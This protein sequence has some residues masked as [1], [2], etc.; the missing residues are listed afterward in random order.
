MAAWL[1]AT[2]PCGNTVAAET[3]KLALDTPFLEVQDN[4]PNNDAK[5]G[6]FCA[7][8]V[9]MDGSV[10]VFKNRREQGIITVKRSEDG[11]KTWG[12]E[13]EVGKKVKIDGDMTDDGRYR[14]AH[15]GWSELG[16][17]IVDENTGD[18]MV[19]PT[20][21]KT[22]QILYRSKDHG[23]TWKTEKTVIQPDVNGWLC[24][25]MNCETGITLRYGKKKGRLLMPTRVFVGYLNK[26]QNRKYYDKH[27]SNA[28]YSD[29]GGKTWI[30]SAPF[31]LGGT[32]EA[33][34]AELSDGRIYYNSRTHN[35]PG[36]RRIAWSY[37][38]GETW[39]DEHE[40]DEL[41]DGPP[42]V[43]GCK[44]GLVRL[45]Y[46]D[47]DILV[48][49]R[50]GPHKTPRRDITVWVSFDGGKTWPVNR[51]VYNKGSYTWLA[52]G[53][54][55]SP[56]EGM[57]YLASIW[58]WFARFNLA[59]IMENHSKTEKPVKSVNKHLL[60]DNRLIEDTENAQL[61]VGTAKKHP[62]NPLFGEELPWETDTSHMY[63]DVIFDKEE[64]IYKCWYFS[65]IK[66]WKKDITMGSLATEG[67]GP[68]NKAT[69]Y[70]VSKDGI[71]WDK[72][73]LDVYRY[74]GKPTN[75]VFYGE[76]GAGV[77]KDPR[78]PDPNRRYKLIAGRMPHGKLDAAFSP[79]GIRWSKR[80]FIANARA[81][82]HNN[83]FWA[84]TL[85]KYVGITRAYPVPPG[86]NIHSPRGIR[87]VLRIESDDFVNWTEPKEILRGPTRKAQIYSMPVFYYAGIYLG[88]PAIYRIDTDKRV[89]T[90]LAW[91][92]DTVTW[93]RIT[94][95]TQMVPLSE[96]TDSVD[97]G[98]IYAAATPI[99]LED[100]I[101]IY[102]SAQK[103][104]HKWQP[105]Y[106]SMATLRPD[107]WAG[108]EPFDHSQPAAVHTRPLTCSGKT[109]RITADTE[110]GWVIVVVADIDGNRLGRS[111][112][113]TN[114]VTAA[115]V[116][117]QDG[118]SLAS[119]VGKPIRL[120]FELNVAK[121]YS[122][123][124]GKK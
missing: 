82:T 41:W 39:K 109:L 46:D 49:S 100:E 90:E 9:A 84:P 120:S 63:A 91:S 114:D 74:K 48:F 106:L 94:P 116:Q 29:D 69:L 18:I 54:K 22:A 88:L 20:S 118:F 13:I 28:I 61:T 112:P 19:F 51:I 101:R 105:G 16:N 6:V 10:L 78:D 53:R 107:G 38:C 79:D 42:D 98:C 119:L 24:S 67:K 7:V 65:R 71:K 92:T 80:F 117:W 11:G 108:Y 57:I 76:H 103:K 27:Y 124:F 115:Q 87:T 33:G 102:Y 31:P 3:K 97:W 15:V 123:D 68:G 25:T 99:V 45:R 37:D 32:G 14:G 21:L 34:L 50:P 2:G 95:G 12:S 81:D 23:K 17:T 86:D 5:S 77:F 4:D 55:G 30:P 59:W 96:N 72:P 113:I 36:N 83:A 73:K 66:E 8:A 111:K 62:A 47:R 85:N 43:Y 56:S 110:S 121:I 70:A 1:I 104:P 60:L 122:F 35:R 64:N 40:D 75:I 52:V 58:D 93:N 26:G 44:A 89:H